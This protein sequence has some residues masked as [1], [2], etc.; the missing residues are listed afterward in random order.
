M[1]VSLAW[2][3]KSEPSNEIDILIKEPFEAASNISADSVYYDLA[4][5]TWFYLSDSSF[6][7][8]NIIDLFPDGNIARVN[9][10][11]NGKRNGEQRTYFPNGKL[12]GLETYSQNRLNGLK[13]RW[14]QK[15]GYQLVALLHYRNGKLD[16]E[17]RKWYDTGELYQI[18][19]IKMGKEEGLQRA[20]RK[21]GALYAN[22]E[23]VKGRT[24]GLKR[25]NL[26]YELDNEQVVYIQ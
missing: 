1:I 25:S 6:V 5:S 9:P 2:A 17:Q 19:N 10:V 21:N 4:S 16:G 13:K 7:T 22:Y 8:G 26:C 15:N 12:K 18:L 11:R 3:Y 20:F 14:S 24:F 23:V